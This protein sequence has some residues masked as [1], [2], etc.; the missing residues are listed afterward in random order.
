MFLMAS[1]KITLIFTDFH[2]SSS[3]FFFFFFF[4]CFNFSLIVMSI[5]IPIFLSSSVL[6]FLFL[7]L[8]SLVLS[9]SLYSLEIMNFSCHPES[10]LKK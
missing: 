4:S 7:F 10:V 1:L 3:F 8:K 2:F 5:Y 9:V 6:P